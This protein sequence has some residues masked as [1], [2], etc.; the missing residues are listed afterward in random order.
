MYDNPHLYQNVF[1]LFLK[2][3]FMHTVNKYQWEG[4]I[5]LLR[6]VLDEK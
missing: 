5:S 3:K 4:G 1:L 6:F 2:I